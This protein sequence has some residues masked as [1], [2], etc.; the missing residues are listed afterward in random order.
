MSYSIRIFKSSTRY[1]VMSR[2]VVFVKS[3]T[4]DKLKH[5][6]ISIPG[7]LKYNYISIPVKAI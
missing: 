6:N 5:K 1:I 3:N 4:S 7:E 2:D